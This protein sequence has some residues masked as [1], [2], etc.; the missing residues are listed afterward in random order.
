M[1]YLATALISLGRLDEAHAR[2]AAT[3]DETRRILHRGFGPILSLRAFVVSGGDFGGPVGRL[4]CRP[5]QERWFEIHS[6]H[7]HSST[8]HDSRARREPRN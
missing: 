4:R 7:L 5:V 3:L 1:G 8:I 6:T 2:I